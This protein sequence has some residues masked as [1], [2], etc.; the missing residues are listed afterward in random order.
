MLNY[1]K[2]QRREVK[3]KAEVAKNF[4]LIFTTV[5]NTKASTAMLEP[6]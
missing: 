5:A 4:F 6:H 2:F 3:Y 1:R